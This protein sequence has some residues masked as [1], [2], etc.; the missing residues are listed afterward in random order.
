ML[1]AV[2]EP[3]SQSPSHI[4]VLCVI[5][6]IWRD[7]YKV[8]QSIFQTDIKFKFESLYLGALTSE[9]VFKMLLMLYFIV[10]PKCC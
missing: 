2:W 3:L 8:V 5:D 4:L 9:N 7:V 6:S 1:A 10:D